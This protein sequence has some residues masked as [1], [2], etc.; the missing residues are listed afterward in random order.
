M[1]NYLSNIYIYIYK[2]N[3]ND[4]RTWNNLITE[5]FKQIIKKQKTYFNIAYGLI[6]VR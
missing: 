5:T 6:L 3:E 4:R 1:F 2:R